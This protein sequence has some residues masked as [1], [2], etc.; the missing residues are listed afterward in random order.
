MMRPGTLS[1]IIG[2]INLIKGDTLSVAFYL[3]KKA[4]RYNIYG[5]FNTIWRC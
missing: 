1:A 2:K 5:T 4:I 3:E